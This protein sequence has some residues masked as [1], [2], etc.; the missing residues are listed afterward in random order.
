MNNPIYECVVDGAKFEF[1]PDVS[2]GRY[3]R[4]WKVCVCKYC[5][6]DDGALPS[7]EFLARLKALRI[8]PGY[9][10]CERSPT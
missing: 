5:D 3:I 2:S 9:N 8:T 6:A 7:P 1:N 10:A 4:E